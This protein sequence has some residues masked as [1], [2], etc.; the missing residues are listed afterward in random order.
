MNVLI[1]NNQLNTKAFYLKQ[2]FKA[3]PHHFLKNSD[4]RTFV[5][6]RSVIHI[7]RSFNCFYLAELCK[8]TV[9]EILAHV[10]DPLLKCIDYDQWHMV[11]PY[12]LDPC[13]DL[14]LERL[15]GTEC[16][17]NSSTARTV[18]AAKEKEYMKPNRRMSIEE[19]GK[20]QYR[21]ITTTTIQLSTI[22]HQW[23][24]TD[25]SQYQPNSIMFQ[26]LKS[27]KKMKLQQQAIIETRQRQAAFTK[28]TFPPSPPETKKRK[29]AYLQKPKLKR[30]LPPVQDHNLHLLAN[31]AIR[32]LPD[33][34]FLLQP[35]HTD[36]NQSLRLPSIQS[37]LSI[38]R[39]MD[40][41]C[42]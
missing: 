29:G 42:A 26:T 2:L 30:V 11:T 41:S 8:L 39:N 33:S 3:N 16:L 5:M 28:I 17:F 25:F 21:P 18:V 12:Q 20:K 38:G 14:D 9:D 6:T 32:G 4:G 35:I 37:M 34:T 19:Q 40:P 36:K 7:A 24:S 15:T 10:A 23:L 22:L 31:Q 1:F 27:V 13:P